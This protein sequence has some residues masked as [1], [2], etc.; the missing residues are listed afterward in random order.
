MT[1]SPEHNA[2]AVR[3]LPSAREPLVAF[4]RLRAGDS[5]W[6]L[7]SALRLPR[8]GR[9]SFAGADPWLV[10][11]ARG[12]RV[13]ADCRRAVRPGIPVGRRAL[14]GDFFELARALLPRL[15]LDTEP[16]LPFV[17]GAVGYLGYELAER[18]ERLDL[19]GDDDLGLPDAVLL[20]VDRLLVWDHERDRAWALA[21]GCAERPDRA[22]E[23]AERSVDSLCRRLESEPAPPSARRRRVSA[24][25]FAHFDEGRYAKAVDRVKEEIAAGNLYQAN[26]T[27]RM[28]RDFA[29]DPWSLYRSLRRIN[30]APFACF[31]ELPEVCIV[32][33]S[34]ELFLRVGVDGR[35]ESRPIKGTR[36][37]GRHASEDAAL[38]A[39]LAASEKDRAEN[40]MIVD[41]MRND[42][43]RVCE[44]GSVAAPELM[45]IEEYA[46]V[47]QLVSAVTGRLRAD[48]DV[49]DLLRATFPPG[50]MTGAPKIA[51]MQL[52]GRLEPVRRGVYSG[53]L[54]YL[55]ARGGADLSV[56]IRTLLVC[57]GR[58]HMHAGGAIVADSD[59]RDEWRET[60]DKAAPLRAALDATT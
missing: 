31:L 6:L 30:P 34:P 39:D 12:E 51:A 35:V 60:L 26:L 10:L 14:R 5:P 23:A 48:C 43:G 21:L 36:R 7:D 49:F 25:P 45:R 1:R 24:P 38:R 16:Q 18:L 11:R 58:A 2:L 9:F 13:E 29:G 4:E 53:A 46:S 44:T 22:R 19:G 40:L 52:L 47:F 42:L 32:G 27:H 17:G 50:S 33:S 15:S 3:E 57:E 20:Y 41:L 8:L 54:G 37:R 56:V 55:D 28:E 59:P